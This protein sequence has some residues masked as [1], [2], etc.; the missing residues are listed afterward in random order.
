MI[1]GGVEAQMLSRRI[2]ISGTA[3]AL[4]AP[5]LIRGTAQAASDIVRRDVMDMAP[6]DPFFADYAKAVAQMHDLKD[7]RSWMSQAHI[8]ADHCYHGKDDFLHWHRHYLRNFEKICAKLSGNPNFAL[9]YWNWSKNDGRVPA[10]FFDLPELNV[11]HWKDPGQYDGKNWPDIDTLPKRGLTKERGLLNDPVRGGAFTVEALNFVKSM[12]TTR[13]FRVA[14]EGNPHGGGHV[15]AGTL[16]GPQFG[17]IGSGLSPLD[18][19]FWLHHCMVDR[20]WAE[21]QRSG[22]ETADPQSNYSGNFVDA[23][24]NS[25]EADSG[26]ALDFKK[27]GYTYDIFKEADTTPILVSDLVELR[28][29]QLKEIKLVLPKVA[30]GKIGAAPNKEEAM[31]NVATTIT[32]PVPDLAKHVANLKALSDAGL[33]D[34]SG[35]VVAKLSQV[36]APKVNDLVVNVFVDCPYLAPNTPSTDP[37]YAGTFGFFGTTHAMAGM[38]HGNQEFVVDITRAV[39]EVGAKGDQI[40]VQLMPLAGSESAQSESTFTVGEVEVLSL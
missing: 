39:K 36:T 23:D 11:E 6:D 19:I 21:W 9:P 20:L 1:H 3:I 15:I 7:G 14:L 2:V 17:H 33:G 34:T 13:L 5:F 31:A 22:N 40:R 26:T 38:D 25:V 12:P 8:H 29:K 10:P 16:A 30:T 32:V 28:V 35:R 37:H 4:T 27:L 24:G 18:P